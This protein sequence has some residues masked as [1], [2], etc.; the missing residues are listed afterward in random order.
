L[1]D[2][3]PTRYPSLRDL[4]AKPSNFSEI[5]NAMELSNTIRAP[6]FAIQT[7]YRY[8]QRIAND[9]SAK[10]L[11]NYLPTL[12]EVHEGKDRKK[13]VN[14]PAFGG[15]LFATFEPTLRNR[16]RVLETTG[17]IRLLGNP[18]QPEAVPEVE[19]ESLQLSLNSGAD[20]IRHP[21]LATGTLLRIQHG[22]LAGLEGRLVR[23]ANAL[24]LVVCVASVGQ[25]IAVE[26]AREDVSPI[27]AADIFYESRLHSMESGAC[28]VMEMPTRIPHREDS[29]RMQTLANG[30]PHM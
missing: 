19:I 2:C 9:L 14:M 13:S 1:I 10:G 22:P 5:V 26:V 27:E 21:F 28:E 3:R 24:R 16:V 4:H 18:G 25:A 30:S 8:E 7:R 15:Y 29:A 23:T 20:C 6:W 11:E 12:S 17:V